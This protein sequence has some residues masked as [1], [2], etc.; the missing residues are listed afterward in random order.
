MT[1]G[2]KMTPMATLVAIERKKEHVLKYLLTLEPDVNFYSTDWFGK[3]SNPLAL[4]V[5]QENL[6]IIRV[7]LNAGAS[8]SFAEKDEPLLRT[9]SAK[10][11]KSIVQLLLTKGAMANF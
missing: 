7:L 3:P 11:Y 8:I 1:I 9:A 4:A 6:S 10:G 5:A 2:A